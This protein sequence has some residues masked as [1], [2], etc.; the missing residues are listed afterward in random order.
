MSLLLNADFMVLM[1]PTTYR[2]GKTSTKAFERS[3]D[4]IS[5]IYASERPRLPFRGH[6]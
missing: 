1:T 5:A 6:C 4:Q 3:R 2:Q